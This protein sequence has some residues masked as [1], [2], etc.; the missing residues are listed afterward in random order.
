[1][2]SAHDTS[3]AFSN[4]VLR[5]HTVF[6]MAKEAEM[7]ELLTTYADGQIEM[8]RKAM[9]SFDRLIPS[10]EQIKTDP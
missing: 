6:E 2:T 5:E 4:E 1:M 3:L 9:E 8:Y 7:K 10:L